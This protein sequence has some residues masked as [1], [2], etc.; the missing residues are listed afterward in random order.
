MFARELPGVSLGLATSRLN[1]CA[2]LPDGGGHK[3]AQV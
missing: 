3:L 1:T 2:A